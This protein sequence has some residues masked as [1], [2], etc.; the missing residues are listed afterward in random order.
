MHNAPQHG[1]GPTR[2]KKVYRFPPYKRCSTPATEPV[3]E[4][5]PPISPPCIPSA[6]SPTTQPSGVTSETTANAEKKPTKTKEGKVKVSN[7]HF[8][9]IPRFIVQSQVSKRTRQPAVR[10]R[11]HRIKTQEGAATLVRW[12]QNRSKPPRTMSFNEALAGK[13]L[14]CVQSITHLIRSDPAAIK[15]ISTIK[16]MK[17][18]PRLIIGEAKDDEA[19]S[20]AARKERIRRGT[21]RDL[22]QDLSR[23]YP[24]D[25]GMWSRPKL[26]SKCEDCHFFSGDIPLTCFLASVGRFREP[27]CSLI[28]SRSRECQVG[29]ANKLL[30]DIG[31][32]PLFLCLT[33]SDPW[34]PS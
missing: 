19:V 30:P 5:E 34:I 27:P 16:G 18:K 25:Q 24:R 20:E 10:P 1:T 12:A 4:V 29:G 3:G 7:F 8:P 15:A 32:V 17:S 11:V 14:H 6:G 28:A 2:T 9:R 23:Y 26:L 31:L 22:Y 13:S 33:F 21:E